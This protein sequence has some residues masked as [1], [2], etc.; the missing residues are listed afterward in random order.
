[1]VALK[2]FS[3]VGISLMIS[4]TAAGKE[5]TVESEPCLGWLRGTLKSLDIQC[6][7]DGEC[8]AALPSA[9]ECVANMN[10]AR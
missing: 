7:L 3:L 4:R 6:V 10:E 1:M 2:L 8:V 9:A 5:I